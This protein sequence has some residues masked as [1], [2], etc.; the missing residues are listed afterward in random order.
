MRAT[1]SEGKLI[2]IYKGS[3]W[4][5]SQIQFLSIELAFTYTANF[6]EGV[7]FETSFVFVGTKF[8]SPYLIQSKDYFNEPPNFSGATIHQDTVVS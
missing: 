4:S 7:V 6:F 5:T 3:C 2:Y 1:H 8:L